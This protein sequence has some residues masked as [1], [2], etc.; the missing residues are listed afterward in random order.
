M[1]INLINMVLLSPKKSRKQ[2]LATVKWVFMSFWCKIQLSL[3][4]DSGRENWKYLHWPQ[5]ANVTIKFFLFA[6]NINEWKTCISL[7]NKNFFW[8]KINRITPVSWSK[9]FKRRTKQILS[10]GTLISML[11]TKQ[12]EMWVRDFGRYSISFVFGGDLVDRGIPPPPPPSR[13]NNGPCSWSC[14]VAVGERFATT[15]LRPSHHRK[16]MKFDFGVQLSVWPNHDNFKA[17]HNYRFV[18]SVPGGLY[19]KQTY[20]MMCTVATKVTLFLPHHRKL[21]LIFL[22][23]FPKH[24][25][26][27]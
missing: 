18:N 26:S 19:K 6:M 27:T 14:I 3:Y 11:S 10:L 23:N 25:P 15:S 5:C 1:S 12:M 20:F 22:N 7:I 9:L 21:V 2:I 17:K 13:K 8:N 16:L 4:R 24:W